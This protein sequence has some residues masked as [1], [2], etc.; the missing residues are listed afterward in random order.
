MWYLSGKFSRE[1]ICFFF[2]HYN[3]VWIMRSFYVTKLG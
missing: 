2:A 3:G 1:R